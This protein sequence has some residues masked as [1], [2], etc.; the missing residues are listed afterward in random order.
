MIKPKILV[1]GSFVMDL[2]VTTKRFPNA[3][4][5]V[6]GCDFQTAP[7]GK[8]AN[9]AVQAARLG[10]EVTMYGKVGDDDFGKAVLRTVRESGVNISH[11]ACTKET[12]TAIGNVQIQSNDGGTENRILLI[13]GANM[14]LTV[15]DIR[16]LQNSISKY[17]MVVLQNEIPMEVNVAVAQYAKEAGV[18]VMFNPAPSGVIPKELLSCLTYISPNEHETEDITGIVPTDE[19]SRKAA[20]YALKK[21]GVKNVLMTLGEN[22]CMFFD[23]ENMMYGKSVPCEKVVD[24]TAAGDSFIGAFCTAVASKKPIG[25][26]LKFAN[27]T[28][29]ITVSRMG[30][31]PSL[32]T[33]EEV[34]HLMKERKLI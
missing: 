28:A 17:D 21:L 4:E 11:V 3:G 19:E 2:I 9:Q 26:V 1:V 8:G 23:G 14:K 33:D 15:D 12:S 27:S 31:M 29:S 10:A 22:G 24:P 7:G 5:T 32:P 20:A 25:E 18:P 13:P 16:D 34:V 6:L 30:A